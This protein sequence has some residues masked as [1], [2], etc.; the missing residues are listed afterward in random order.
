MMNAAANFTPLKVQSTAGPGTVVHQLQE[1]LDVAQQLLWISTREASFM[2]GEVMILDG[3][4]SNT[5]AGFMN[6][7]QDARLA[8]EMA[9][10][11]EK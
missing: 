1:P 6:Y 10:A 11:L 3:G 9:N 4:M 2:N 8:D 7:V 5:D